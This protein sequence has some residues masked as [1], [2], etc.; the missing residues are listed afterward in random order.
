MAKRVGVLE[1]DQPLTSVPRTFVKKSVARLLVRRLEARPIASHLIQMLRIEA[2][3]A[4]RE[5]RAWWDG[6]LGTGNALPFSAPTDPS[7]HYHYEIPMAGD[8]GLWRHQRKVCG[9]QECRLIRRE[10]AEVL[11]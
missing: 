9:C 1:A 7:K 8:R 4:M 5:I 3:Q 2:R 10:I 11:A 6:I